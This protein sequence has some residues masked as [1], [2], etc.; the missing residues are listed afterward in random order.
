[1]AHEDQVRSTKKAE[2]AGRMSTSYSGKKRTSI[3]GDSTSSAN[4]SVTDSRPSTPTPSEAKSAKSS[5]KGGTQAPGTSASAAA[6][7]SAKPMDITNLVDLDLPSKKRKR[8]EHVEN[9]LT[10]L[11]KQEVE[12]KLPEKFRIFL[13]DDWDSV[14]RQKKLLNVPSRHTVD[15]VI[16]SYLKT[17]KDGEICPTELCAGIRDYF[18]S[19]LGNQLL[20]RFERFQYA[21]VIGSKRKPSTSKDKDEPFPPMTSV[22]GPVHLLRLFTRLGSCLSYTTLNAKDVKILQKSLDDFFQF[23][24]E[25]F[26]EYFSLDEYGL[27]APEYQRKAPA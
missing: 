20:Y 5:T 11:V 15:S 19:M 18:N 17:K 26:E 4:V 25:H 12:I 10:Y 27:S 23:L 21:D 14:C 16:E 6:A 22:Y 9:E 1:M 13:V 3:A 7:L 8:G 24:L 2:K